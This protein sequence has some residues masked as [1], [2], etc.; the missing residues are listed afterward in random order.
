MTSSIEFSKISDEDLAQI[1]IEGLQVYEDQIQIMD[2][3]RKKS[4]DVRNNL[5]DIE[6]ELRKRKISI[7]PV[8]EKNE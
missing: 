4:T 2:Y 3:M 6:G 8:E 1:Y 7:K 5:H